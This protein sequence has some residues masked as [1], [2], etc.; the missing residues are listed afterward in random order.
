L[1]IHITFTSSDSG[2]MKLNSILYVFL[3]V[4][5]LASATEGGTIRGGTL[6]VSSNDDVGRYL[7][8]KPEDWEDATTSPIDED[9]DESND[10]DRTDEP[11]TSNT[12]PTGTPSTSPTEAVH[13]T[14][15]PNPVINNTYNKIDIHGSQNEGIVPAMIKGADDDR[16]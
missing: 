15:A 13:P 11:T 3:S 8:H 5:F 9:N 10:D 1:L 16:D 14:T 2:Q 7:K 4:A 6:T 12:N